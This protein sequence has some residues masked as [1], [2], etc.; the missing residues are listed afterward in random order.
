MDRQEKRPVYS[1]LRKIRS[2]FVALA[3]LI[4]PNS[5]F[6]VIATKQI[7][8]GPLKRAC[9][10]FLNCHAC[11]TAY[12]A[13]P[14]GVMQHF[15]AVRQ[16]P[17]FLVGFLAAVGMVFGRAACGWLCPFG[18]IQDQLYKIKSR[19]FGIPRFLS[20]GKYVSLVVLALGLPFFTEIHWFS[21]IC[22][23]GTLIA[24]VP[25]VA[26]NPDDPTLGA[27]VIEPGMLG[28]L[29]VLKISILVL[30][31][32]LFVVTKR[33]FCR[34][35]CPL[36][37]AYALF[38]RVSLMRLQVQGPCAECDLCV[39]VCPVDI[40]VSDDPNSPDCIRCLKCTVCKHVSVRWSITDELR[41]PTVAEAPS[42]GR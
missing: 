29:Y 14:I 20:K 17:Y 31:L 5:Y 19:K 26:W 39:E 15:A 27:P 37:A 6:T 41:P 21:R 9:V 16:V 18:W 4:L 40:R 36:G 32:V 28:W 2:P 25:W 1:F 33:P 35:L 24:G 11:P 12:M 22:P 3:G 42:Q 34:T 7:Y 13:C 8:E 38:N 10:P 30:F 23:W